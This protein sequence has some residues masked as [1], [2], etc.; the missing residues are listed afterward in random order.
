MS[1]YLYGAAVQGIQGY[2]FQTNKLKDIIEASDV[3]EK[4]CTD[5][6]DEFDKGGEDVVRAAGNIKFV[7]N[8]RADC[9]NAVLNFPKKVMQMAPGITISQAVT[10]FEDDNDFGDAVDRVE[11][12]LKTQRNKPPKSVTLGLMGIKRAN[13]TGLPVPSSE[14]DKKKEDA[15]INTNEDDE[16]DTYEVIHSKLCKKSFGRDDNRSTFNVSKFTGKNDWIAVI[17]AD[18]NGIGSIVQKVGKNKEK[19]KEFSKNLDEAT[20]KAANVAF[21]AVYEIIEKDRKFFENHILPIRPVV[22]SGDDMTVIIRGDLAMLYAKTFIVEF[23]KSTREL[24]GKIINDN[25]I[26]ADGKDYLTACAGIAFIKA[27]YPF[28][29]GYELAEDLCS[30]AKKVAKAKIN[31][32]A[33]PESCL[34]FHKVQDSFITDYSDIVKRELTVV[35]GDAKKQIEKITFQA[36]PYFTMEKDG[37]IALMSGGKDLEMCCQELDKEGNEGIRAGIRNWISLLLTDRAK[38]EQRLNRMKDIYFSRKSFI[39]K[40]TSEY[41]VDS[42]KKGEKEKVYIAYDALA[43]HTILNQETNN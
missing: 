7:F 28:Y 36:G 10:A 15:D 1:K 26:F 33:L 34:M 17:H 32:G 37:T 31:E 5:V 16:K 2:I 24:L 11:E 6:F 18:G 20:K 3:V 19:F 41:E 38:A 27:S 42:A 13:D 23:E 9:E 8:N 35:E 43:Y 30:A 39:E 21:D 29:Y 25:N 12:I 22:L 40:M 4:I 14:K